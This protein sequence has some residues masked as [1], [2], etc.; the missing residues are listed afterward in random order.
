MSKNALRV[1]LVTPYL[2]R[3]STSVPAAIATALNDQG[4]RLKVVA[5]SPWYGDEPRSDSDRSWRCSRDRLGIIPVV[6]TP[7]YRGYS[8]STI[9]RAATYGSFAASATVGGRK[10][11]GSSDVN[12][13]YGSQITAAIPAMVAKAASG[14]PFVLQIQ[15]LWPDSVFATD[16]LTSG[17]GHAAALRGLD[18]LCKAA[19]RQADAIVVISPEIR[20]ALVERGVAENKVEVV[21]NWVDEDSWVPAP[22]DGALRRQFG[23]TERDF[24]MLYAGNHGLAQSLDTIVRVMAQEPIPNL[25]LVLVGDGPERD[26]VV[27]LSE[28]ICARQVHALERVPAETVPRLAADADAM[29]VSLSD[30]AVFETAIPS[31]MQSIMAMAR[32]VFLVGSGAAERVVRES[33]SGWVATPGDP[34]SIHKALC[35]MVSAGRSFARVRGEAGR[36]YYTNTMSREIGAQALAE[37]L[38]SA[39]RFRNAR[40]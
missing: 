14:S 6:R 24:L 11:L 39:A 5:G 22:P 21:Y 40:C 32:P 4:F 38:R 8:N 34:S 37:T 19:Y 33:Q 25:H 26:R 2:P 18:G 17:V 29:L 20:D 9:R 12:L 7:V 1:G 27:D 16:F 35:A 28:R 30:R 15:D 23:L 13:V 10:I 31:K 3:D 36:K